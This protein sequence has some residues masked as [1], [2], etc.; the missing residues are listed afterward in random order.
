MLHNGH[1]QAVGSC[2]T[3]R[4]DRSAQQLSVTVKHIPVGFVHHLRLS[5]KHVP[6]ANTSTLL[7]YAPSPLFLGAGVGNWVFYWRRISQPTAQR[8]KA[9]DE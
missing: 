2:K 7:F 3:N 5:A 1:E 4:V 8:L 9:S 6:A